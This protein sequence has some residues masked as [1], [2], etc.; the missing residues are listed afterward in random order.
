MVLPGAQLFPGALLPLYIFEPRYR[1]MLDWSLEHDRMFCIA[2]L[3]PGVTEAQS[4]DDFHHVIG[5]GL[6]RASVQRD[7]ATSHLVLQGLAR[8]QIVGFLQDAPFRIAELRELSSEPA[9]PQLDKGLTAR[10]LDTFNLLFDG[11]SHPSPAL[12]AELQ[13]IDNSGV[14]ADMIA[15]AC[16]HD[17]EDRQSIFEELNASRRVAL[18]IDYLREEGSRFSSES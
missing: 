8:M 2:P 1:A 16:L 15:H 4:T 11:P 18:L 10:L 3:K 14:L 17:S 6:I 12:A 13:K 5:I 9:P 7:D